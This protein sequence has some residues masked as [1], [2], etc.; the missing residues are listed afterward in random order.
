MSPDAFLP[1]ARGARRSEPLLSLPQGPASWGLRAAP[2]LAR[3]R[4]TPR[5]LGGM[6]RTAWTRCWRPGPVSRNIHPEARVL[7]AGRLGISGPPTRPGEPLAR[8][9]VPC[10]AHLSPSPELEARLARRVLEIAWEPRDVLQPS[11]QWTRH[12]CR[13]KLSPKVLSAFTLVRRVRG[14]GAGARG[15][16]MRFFTISGCPAPAG[17]VSEQKLES[18]PAQKSGMLLEKAVFHPAQSA[19][20]ILEL[21]PASWASGWCFLS[22]SNCRGPSCNPDWIS[23]AGTLCPGGTASLCGPG[24]PEL[25]V[26][27]PG[28]CPAPPSTALL[29]PDLVLLV[30]FFR[31]GLCGMLITPDTPVPAAGQS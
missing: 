9:P 10:R 2:T 4:R 7:R 23:R 1:G 15:V 18:E 30:P 19:G 6:G 11:P 28:W 31:R 17:L 27:V 3:H 24:C 29:T 8:L 22:A 21:P 13:R 20:G 26:G 12:L 14:L 25:M 16:L 5:P